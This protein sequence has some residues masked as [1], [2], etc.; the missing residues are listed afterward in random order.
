M[1]P[2]RLR[3][4]EQER[5]LSR[6]PNTVF[7]APLIL[8]DFESTGASSLESMLDEVSICCMAGFVTSAEVKLRVKLPL[9]AE[10]RTVDV[11][12][13]IVIG[14]MS[15]HGAKRTASQA[16]YERSANE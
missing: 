4:V 7:P 16:E 13:V 10:P 1:T 12:D 3:G 15:R 6:S 11:I 14:P 5:P 8:R 9:V 2:H